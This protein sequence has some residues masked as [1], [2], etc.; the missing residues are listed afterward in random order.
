PKG[1]RPARGRLPAHRA[2]PNAAPGPWARRRRSLVVL[3]LQVAARDDDGLVVFLV[4]LVAFV[5]EEHARV[6]R[7]R[8]LE[9]TADGHRGGRLALRVRGQ[10]RV[11]RRAADPVPRLRAGAGGNVPGVLALRLQAL[12]LDLG[13]EALLGHDLDQTRD[14]LEITLTRQL[15]LPGGLRDLRI[16][17]RVVACHESGRHRQQQKL[18][19]GPYSFARGTTD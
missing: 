3:H 5:H 1:D 11:V 8:G 4:L 18:A 16:G 10:G 9:P 7:A 13:G 15:G 12:D 2:A 6:V 19:H 14:V 17:R